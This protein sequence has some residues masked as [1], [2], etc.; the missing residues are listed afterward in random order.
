VSPKTQQSEAVT[1]SWAEAQR[2]LWDGWLDALHQ[3]SPGASPG[4]G[5]GSSQELWARALATWE[6][7]VRQSLDAQSAAMDAWINSVGAGPNVPEHLR[8][9][10]EQAHELTRGWTD[11]Q[12]RLWDA[13]FA[14]VRQF[15]SNVPEQRRAGTPPV[16]DVWQQIARP[17]L[18]AQAAWLRQWSGLLAGTPKTPPNKS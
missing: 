5:T 2:R 15:A 10:L 7:F 8:A 4:G 14:A 16:A 6:P 13:M 9:R 12:R 1:E 17:V 18:E 11:T 3:A